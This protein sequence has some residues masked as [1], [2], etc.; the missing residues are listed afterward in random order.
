MNFFVRLANNY[1][2]NL[3]NKF[4]IKLFS[5]KIRIK[6]IQKY[7]NAADLQVSFFKLAFNKSTPSLHFLSEM[8]PNSPAQLFELSSNSNSQLFQDLFV[9]NELNYLQ[10]GFYVEFGAFDGLT[11][12]NTLLL[13][14]YYNWQGILA[15]PSKEF[16]PKLEFNRGNNSLDNR[17]VFSKTGVQILFN[18]TTLPSLST[19]DLFSMSDGWDRS[20]GIKYYIETISLQD[21]LI[22]NN[23]PRR[24]NYLSID[25]EGSEYEILN[26]FNFE[27]YEIDIITVEHNFN[28][29]R[30]KIYKLLTS[31]GY[32][33]K[34]ERI[35][36]F[37]DWYVHERMN[38]Q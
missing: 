12:S 18:E 27:S 33:R 31:N 23:A 9:I 13:E 29:S 6:F 10:N 28:E 5:I 4:L 25:T 7:F 32:I 26:A 38:S 36:S 1:V 11:D 22:Q 34:Y 20:S 15:E 19:I 17:A 16:F 37:D 8:E 3:K 24:I 21:L 2:P 35:S 14:K 30:I